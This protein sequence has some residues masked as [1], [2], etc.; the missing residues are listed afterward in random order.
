MENGREVLRSSDPKNKERRGFF[1]EERD[2][3]LRRRGGYSENFSSFFVIR[4]RRSKNPPIFDL[5][6]R[7]SK[8][9]DLQFSIFGAE[10]RRTSIFD[11]RLR[12]QSRRSDEKDAS[13]GF[14]RRTKN[15]PIIHL[16]GTKNE[17]PSIFFSRPKE[18]T[19]NL[20]V[21]LLSIFPFLWAS[22]F[23]KYPEIWIFRPIFH[24]K[25]RSEDRGWPSNPI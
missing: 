13:L 21:L 12:K 5:R 22:A 3:V 23:I 1:E 2:M 11:L 10:D 4:S 7:I 20:L 14:F 25:D 6:V 18:W 9:L 19:T 24:L 17:E 16:I 15:T 8:K